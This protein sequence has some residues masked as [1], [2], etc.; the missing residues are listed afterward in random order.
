MYS[1]GAGSREFWMHLWRI[2]SKRNSR[3]GVADEP[4]EELIWDRR[5]AK[6]RHGTRSTARLLIF[7]YT[8]D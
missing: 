4:K 8:T 5:G 6:R 3:E 1:I 2:F 7:P